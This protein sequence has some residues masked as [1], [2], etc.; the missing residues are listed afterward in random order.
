MPAEPSRETV[1]SLRAARAAHRL[2]SD[3]ALSRIDGLSAGRC[4]SCG[5]AFT[6]TDPATREQT[7][8]PG[9]RQVRPQMSGHAVRLARFVET[10]CRGLDIPFVAVA[11]AP[12]ASSI[13]AAGI[14]PHGCYYVT[15]V[16]AAR[17]IGMRFEPGLHPPPDLV[18][19]AGPAGEATSSEPA[20]AAIGVPELW[21]SDG[22]HL[23]VLLLDGGAYAPSDASL[24]FPFLPLPD[25]RALLARVNGEDEHTVTRA[26]G[27]WVRAL[28]G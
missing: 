17:T 26:F 18:L 27:Q 15:N 22:R 5:R 23:E 13:E 8:C 1:S 4:R 19:D 28:R 2:A 10:L 9:C 24:S 14:H 7:V 25:L 11:A 12:F 6:P 20:C 16:A 21:R 3:V